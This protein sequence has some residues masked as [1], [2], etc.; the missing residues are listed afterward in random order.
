MTEVCVNV[1]QFFRSGFHLLPKNVDVKYDSRAVTVFP[2]RLYELLKVSSPSSTS[3]P[4]FRN[5]FLWN[6]F[7]LLIFYSFAC[8]RVLYVSMKCI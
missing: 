6:D 8:L 2:Q 7:L 3:F 5:S 1:S 4:I